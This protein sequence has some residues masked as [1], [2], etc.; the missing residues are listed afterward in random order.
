MTMKFHT[1]SSPFSPGKVLTLVVVVV[2][3]CLLQG[4]WCRS[5]LRSRSRSRRAGSGSLVLV[6]GALQE[7]NAEVYDTIVTLAGGKGQARIGIVTAASADPDGSYQY[8]SN[9]FRYRYGVAS[10][11][12]VNASVFD[13]AVA[14]DPQLVSQV[15]TLTGFFFAGGDQS[16]VV[17]AMYQAGRVA[18]PVLSAIKDQFQAGVVVS[19]TS[20]GAS[21]MPSSVMVTGGRSWNALKYGAM[22]F[23]FSA[24]NLTYDSAGGLGFLDGYVIDTHFANRG[25]EGRMIRLLS[26]TRAL[27]KGVSRGFGV[28]E[29]TALVITQ[30]G[31][32]QAE[33]KVIGE[34]GV[35]FFD[36]TTAFVDPSEQDF[37]IRDVFVTYL[38]QGDT[39]NLYTHTVTFASDKGPLQGNELY[40]EALTS[41]DIFF[42]KIGNSTKKPE[43][44]RVATSIFDER[45]AVWSY[46]VTL[47]RNPQFRVEMSKSGREAV[48]YVKRVNDFH[49]DLHSYK[50]MYVG[51]HV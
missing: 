33:G 35:T 51:I 25:R 36:L 41:D 37:A 10:T 21:C 48:G 4:V 24:D 39:F 12:Q 45:D 50:D 43:F 26:D 44:V 19:G 2:G 20:A 9:I 29:N 13:R 27:P 8:Y 40:P 46:G 22:E 28:D 18:S 17:D 34:A 15:R 3:A 47:E 14:S 11:L 31:T 6:G 42:G 5:T 49:S 1:F 32:P 30:P 7:D 16:R 38:T 23:S